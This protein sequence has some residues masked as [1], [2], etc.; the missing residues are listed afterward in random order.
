MRH[1]PRELWNL[2]YPD[3][4]TPTFKNLDTPGTQRITATPQKSGYSFKNL[5]TPDIQG[6]LEV[7]IHRVEHAPMGANHLVNNAFHCHKAFA[8]IKTKQLIRR[9]F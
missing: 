3:F 7:I 5:D 1:T 4:Y 8:I 6:V 9:S 2:V